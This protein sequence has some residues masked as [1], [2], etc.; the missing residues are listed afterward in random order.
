M[1]ALMFY[2]SLLPFFFRGA[3]APRTPRWDPGALGPARPAQKRQPFPEMATKKN[4]NST[5]KKIR[6]NKAKD[7]SGPKSDKN[8]KEI[9][10][11][12]S[13]QDRRNGNLKIIIKVMKN[14]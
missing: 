8:A 13:A 6:K 10:D 11:Q 4:S 7:A 12:K 5:W 14:R 9:D 3:A 2:L 1:V